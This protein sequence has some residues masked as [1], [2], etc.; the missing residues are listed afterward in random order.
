M[1][2][3]E[4][5]LLI[6]HFFSDPKEVDK[7]EYSLF[8]QNTFKDFA[9]PLAWRHFSGDSG[10][11]VGFKAILYIPPVLS[12][13]TSAYTSRMNADIIFIV[14]SLTGTTLF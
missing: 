10:D 2:K 12:V 9:Q 8:Y 7:D 14:I 3:S 6:L 5:V 4:T 1:K 11:G 13:Q